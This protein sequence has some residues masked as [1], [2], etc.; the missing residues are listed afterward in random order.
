MNMNKEIDMIA[1]SCG[2]HQAR[3][4]ERRHVRLVQPTGGSIALDVLYPAPPLRTG[5]TGGL[6]GA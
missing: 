1:H 2:V 6:A 3:E 5:A 4:L